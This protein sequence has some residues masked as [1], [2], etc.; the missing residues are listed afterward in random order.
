MPG[1]FNK[2]KATAFGLCST[3]SSLGGVVFPIMIS[4]L[5]PRVGFPWT[6][7]ISAFLILGLLIMANL[8]VKSRVAPKR[9]PATEANYMAPFKE[10][11]SVFLMGGFFLLTFAIFVPIDYIQV[12]ARASGMGSGILEYIVP[13]LNAARFVHSFSLLGS[14]S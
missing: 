9:G 2:K 12:Q 6:M 4:H 11:A 13:I 1:W 8:T 3:G 7:R 5:I 10:P 14:S